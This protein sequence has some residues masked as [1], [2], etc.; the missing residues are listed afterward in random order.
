M[1]MT[2]PPTSKITNPSGKYQHLEE[3][4][5]VLIEGKKSVLE[6]E[7]YVNF[8]KKTTARSTALPTEATIN[9]Q[10]L[11]DDQK[12]NINSTEYFTFHKK[13]AMK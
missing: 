11:P 9:D 6:S 8:S 7:N 4:S 10:D 3:G 13:E 2:T 12:L 5:F 1:D